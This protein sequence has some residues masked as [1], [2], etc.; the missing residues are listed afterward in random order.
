[1]TDLTESKPIEKYGKVLILDDEE[2]LRELIKEILEASGIKV[3]TAD[4][5]KTAL[6]ILETE[7]FDMILSD[8]QMPE[9]TGLQFLE[10]ISL[11]G[12]LTPLVFLSGFYEKDMLRKSMQLGAFDFL[13]KPISP[14][15]LIKVVEN[16]A[17]VGVLRRKIN[18]I[19]DRKNVK[20]LDFIPEYEKRIS[21][22]RLANYNIDDS[23]S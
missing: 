18:F 5:P 11:Q 6:A 23:G 1:M 15:R 21:Q 3:T 19:R 17:E 4:N 8:V 7:N 20:L 14:I 10:T 12:N 9:M 22:L 2:G 16:A 13:E